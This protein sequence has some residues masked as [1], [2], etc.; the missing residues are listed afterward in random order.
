M[1]Y[2]YWVLA[3]PTGLLALL[4]IMLTLGGKQ[5]TPVTPDWLSLLTSAAVLGLLVW[6]FRWATTGA[7][8]GLAV[9]L[10][11]LSWVVFLGVMLVNGLMHQKTWN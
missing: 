3:V 4:V 1:V 8:P 6:G 9:V 11:V 7:R 10:V 2:V 5:I